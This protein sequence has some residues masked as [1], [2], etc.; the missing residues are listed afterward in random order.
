MRI[1]STQVIFRD[2]E[3]FNSGSSVVC[4]GRMINTNTFEAFRQTDPGK[5]IDTMGRDIVNGIKDG[6]ILQN[7]WK[8]SLFL[9][10]AYSDLKK[11]KF[12]YWVARPTP[13][14]LPEMYYRESPKSMVEEFS[15]DHAEDLCEGFLALDSRSR[16]YF[17]VLISEEDE[18]SVV[19]LAA[20]VEAINRRRGQESGVPNT[21]LKVP[22]DRQLPYIYLIISLEVQ[23][24]IFR[25][26]RSLDKLRTRLAVAQ[27]IMS[28]VLAL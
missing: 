22:T 9:V 20:G 24:S 21:T 1:N 2:P 27:F 11:Y 18:M 15:V 5:F 13:L 17:G 26:L 23:Q 8:L 6:S 28:A 25:I 3:T 16:N 10:L 7:P 14:M 12:Y 4:Y 19:D